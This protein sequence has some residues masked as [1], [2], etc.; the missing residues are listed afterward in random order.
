MDFIVHEGSSPSL[1]IHS[2][3]D[4]PFSPEHLEQHTG[5]PEHALGSSDQGTSLS[6]RQIRLRHDLSGTCTSY[7]VVYSCEL[8]GEPGPGTASLPGGVSRHDQELRVHGIRP[9]RSRAPASVWEHGEA[10]GARSAGFP[11]SPSEGSLRAP[12]LRGRVSTGYTSR[13]EVPTLEEGRRC[14]PGLPSSRS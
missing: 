9:A 1:G 6:P 8:R 7:A 10:S 13:G 14:E 5:Y 11:S 12:S 4:V 2:L 3:P